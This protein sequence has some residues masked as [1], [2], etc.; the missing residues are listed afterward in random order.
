MKIVNFLWLGLFFFGLLSLS[1]SGPNTNATSV[2]KF[3]QVRTQQVLKKLSRLTTEKT[4]SVTIT[5][6]KSKKMGNL[7]HISF[8]DINYGWCASK[9]KL[10]KTGDSGETWQEV[11]LNIPKG[12]FI[13]SLF[14]N[15]SKSGWI[16]LQ[17]IAPTISDY[18]ENHI[19]LLKTNDGAQSWNMV[20][21]CDSVKATQLSFMNESN[22][23]LMGIKYIGI[24]PLRFMSFILRLNDESKSWV[25]VSKEFNGLVEDSTNG[26]VTNGL[27]IRVVQKFNDT[28]IVITN[29]RVIYETSDNGKSWQPVTILEDSEP[30]VRVGV[31]SFGVTEKNHIWFA[32]AAD[33]IEGRQIT[34]YT[35]QLN[36][37]WEGNELEGIFLYTVKHISDGKFIGCGFTKVRED[38][39]WRKKGI[40]LYTSNSGQTWTPIYQN[41]SVNNIN[42]IILI[43]NVAWAVGDEG[44]IFRLNL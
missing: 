17:K 10:F 38:N 15:T 43:E 44:A 14:F 2:N 41:N 39:E 8:S 40:I 21:E 37:T 23:W 29:N 26:G 11:T 30:F 19:W 22:G 20:F 34:L 16:L 35:E 25:D 27:A 1:C 9:D 12:A 42:N 33:A 7:E 4:F 18:K 31:H 5:S 28:A 36:K 32:G 24:A 13:S 6:A 3:N